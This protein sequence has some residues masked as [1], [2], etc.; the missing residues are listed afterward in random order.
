MDAGIAVVST[1]IIT[2]V[3][4]AEPEVWR[5]VIVQY[6]VVIRCLQQGQRSFSFE[7]RPS[8][9]LLPSDTIDPENLMGLCGSS[10]SCQ[11]L[12]HSENVGPLSR[13]CSVQHFEF[14]N[15]A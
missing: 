14:L 5:P 2:Q 8:S 3:A 7:S 4:A 12:V 13:C 9:S 10:S 11:S 1:V 15:L 6:T